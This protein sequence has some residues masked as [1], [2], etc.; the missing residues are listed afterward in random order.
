MEI[1]NLEIKYQE[2]NCKEKKNMKAFKVEHIKSRKYI[3]E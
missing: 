2:L 1:L 3:G